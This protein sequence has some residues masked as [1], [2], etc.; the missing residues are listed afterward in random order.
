MRLTAKQM[1][2]SVSIAVA[3]CLATAQD[4][5]GLYGGVTAGY[6]ALDAKH[7]FSNLAPSGNSN[8]DGALLGGFA[9]YSIQS[10]Q[11]VYGAEVDFEGSTA[12][13]RY[14][15]LTGATS[16]GKAELNWQGSVRAVLGYAGNLG[17]SPALFY[18]TGGYAYGD[19]DFSGGPSAAANNKYS[20][21]LDGWTIGAGIDTR[22][23]NNLSLRTEY[24]YTDYGKSNGTLAP[25]FP[26]VTM[27]VKVEEHAVRIG[28]RMDF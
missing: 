13:G 14:T 10:G 6:A 28:L 2:L 3:P 4:W 7:R 5:S 12:S 19:F 15:N 27:P 20:D 1:V 18:A 22:I 8:P 26:G 11:M 24:R 23:A 25:G 9:G 21:K 17:T 16:S